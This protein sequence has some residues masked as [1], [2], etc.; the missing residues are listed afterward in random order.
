LREG[1]GFCRKGRGLVVEIAARLVIEVRNAGKG[2]GEREERGGREVRKGGVKGGGR[3]GLQSLEFSGLCVS[4]NV[5]GAMPQKDRT[6]GKRLRTRE[7]KGGNEYAFPKNCSVE[8][9]NSK[10]RIDE[11]REKGSAGGNY[12]ESN[13]VKRDDSRWSRK[14]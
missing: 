4:K 10:K 11:G 6:E 2:S 3:R 9:V 7:G 5:F 12:Q 1:N 14:T 13:E 8:K